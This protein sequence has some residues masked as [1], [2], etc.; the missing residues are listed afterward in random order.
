M[1]TLADLRAAAP[2]RQSEWHIPALDWV[3]VFYRY[4]SIPHSSS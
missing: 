1:L 2:L 3:L 4:V